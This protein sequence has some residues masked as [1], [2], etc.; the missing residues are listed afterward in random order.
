MGSVFMLMILFYLKFEPDAVLIFSILWLIYTIPEVYLYLEYLIVNMGVIVKLNNDGLIYHNNG[1]ERA[2]NKDQIE[3]ITYYLTPN[4]NKKS[5]I[6]YLAT[7]SFQFVR[8]VTK[9]GDKVLITCL[10]STK[11]EKDLYSLNIPVKGKKRLF[12]TTS[13]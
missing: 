1:I 8:I 4:A 7:E 5:S 10:L 11:L 3:S 2:I 12:C 9:T 13:I 6:Q